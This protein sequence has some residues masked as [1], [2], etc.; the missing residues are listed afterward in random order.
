MPF[1][2]RKMVFLG[3]V[4]QLRPVCG[5]ALYESSIMGTET[6]TGRRHS[7]EYKRRSARG[8]VLYSDYISKNCIWLSK[9]FHNKGLLLEIMDRV[10]DG[11]QTLSDL[12]KI[13]H[14]QTKYQNTQ[15][16]HGIH[17]SNE[18]CSISSWLDL[19]ETCKQHDP[20][21]R[22]F[23]SKASYHSDGKNDLVVSGLAALPP[24][25]YHFAPDVLCVAKSSE[26]RLITNLNV[27]AGLANSA[28]GT[29]VK[30][31]YNN[32]DVQALLNGHHPPAYC[33]IVNFPQFR[34][35][36]IGEERKFP[37][38]NPHWVPPYRHRF[39]PQTVP[40]WIRK[41]QSPSLC[42]RDQ[43]PLH[44]CRHITTHRCRGRREKSIGFC[45]SQ[46]GKS[47]QSY[48]SR[49]NFCSV[50]CLYTH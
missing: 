50:R 19:W 14:Q 31:I 20:S 41:K 37:L 1:G 24:S 33:I 32:A 10:R 49:Y 43:F 12:D 9:T 26:V 38:Q 5:A 22:L 35:F 39:L 6:N 27:S 34:G 18:S 47:Q 13:L 30:V 2:G 46:F 25:Q 40:G 28:T 3:D 8:L 7:R 4:A 21:S 36:L 44:L 48:S 15:T 16:A 11:S 42:Y 29:V 17:Y 23:I 45:R